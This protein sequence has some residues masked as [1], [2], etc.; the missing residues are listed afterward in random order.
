MG[1]NNLPPA[2]AV[3]F[4][5]NTPQQ[6]SIHTHPDGSRNVDGPSSGGGGEITG[7]MAGSRKDKWGLFQAF[8]F[9]EVKVKFTFCITDTDRWHFEDIWLNVQYNR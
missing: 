4:P 7:F 5:L 9:L 2:D 3:P 1:V 6:K 8:I